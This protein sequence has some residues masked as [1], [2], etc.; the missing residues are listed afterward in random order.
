M[1][2]AKGVSTS[3][4][5]CDAGAPSDSSGTSTRSELLDVGE[6]EPCELPCL[7]EEPGD[8]LSTDRRL[9]HKQ[10]ATS[11]ISVRRRSR[12]GITAS[13]SSNA[14]GYSSNDLRYQ[15]IGSGEKT[16]PR[17]SARKVTST[18]ISSVV[19]TRPA[20]SDSA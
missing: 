10:A 8:R 1:A 19:R 13:A 4:S 7:F 14:A 16:G 6:D 3:R 2:V 9:R 5:G 12:S 11:A 15:T 18:A 20:P 17:P